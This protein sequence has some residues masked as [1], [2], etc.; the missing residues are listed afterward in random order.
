M[1]DLFKAKLKG[2]VRGVLMNDQNAEIRDA[3]TLVEQDKQDKTIKVSA[4]IR[5]TD[6]D[7]SPFRDSQSLVNKDAKALL[8]SELGAV[9]SVTVYDHNV[10]KYGQ[11]LLF[12]TRAGDK[13]G[14]EIRFKR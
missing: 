13:E 4:V 10:E 14:D 1:G 7:L 12:K 5:G 3:D 2:Q 9:Y 11:P 6:K 8:D